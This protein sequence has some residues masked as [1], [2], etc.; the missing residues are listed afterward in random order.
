MKLNW[1][2]GH[3]WK[4]DPLKI[5]TLPEDSFEY[6]FVLT[7]DGNILDWQKGKNNL[8]IL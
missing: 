7:S 4:T 8:F 6:K 5:S 3:Y 2:E 1:A